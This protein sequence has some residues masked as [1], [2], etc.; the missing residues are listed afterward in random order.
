MLLIEISKPLKV[1]PTFPNFVAK[2]AKKSGAGVHVEK[3]GKNAPRHKQKR[4]WKKEI[5]E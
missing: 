3:K 5:H 4:Q 1:K 2:H